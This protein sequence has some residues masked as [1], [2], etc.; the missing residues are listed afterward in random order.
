MKNQTFKLLREYVDL[1][2]IAYFILANI[3]NLFAVLLY[4]YLGAAIDSLVKQDFESFLFYLLITFVCTLLSMFSS[5]LSI[6]IYAAYQVSLS[7][8]LREKVSL[9]LVNS[10]TPHSIEEAGGSGAVVP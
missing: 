8:K 2:G 7:T 9:F 6:F 3:N 4:S 5:L 1:K 10:E